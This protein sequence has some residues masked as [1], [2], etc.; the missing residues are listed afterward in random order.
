MAT[1]LSATERYNGGAIVLHWLL[2]LLIIGN[3]AGGLLAD[4]L[5]EGQ[6]WV[7]PLHKATGILILALTLV[8]IGWRFAFRPPSLLP[9]QSAWQHALTRAVHGLFYVLMIAVPLSGWAMVSS[10]KVLR[11]ISFYGLFEV[12][13]LPVGREVYDFAY[14]AHE[15]LGFAMLGLLILHVG[16]ALWHRFALR[17]ATLARMGIGSR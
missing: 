9:V 13:F 17:D 7:F 8:R 12:P 3:L 6:R 10:A 5:L 2:A 4:S 11:P 14:E 15:L 16:A 1:A